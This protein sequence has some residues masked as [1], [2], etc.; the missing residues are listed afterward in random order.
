MSIFEYY[1]E[2]K[3]PWKYTN[4]MRVRIETESR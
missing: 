4:L 1:L 3:L 2:I